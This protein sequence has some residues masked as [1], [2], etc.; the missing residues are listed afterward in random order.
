MQW[1]F[2]FGSGIKSH[3]YNQWKKS[4]LSPLSANI[5]T[6]QAKKKKKIEN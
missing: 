2:L 4:P 5:A 6:E 1:L 3:I